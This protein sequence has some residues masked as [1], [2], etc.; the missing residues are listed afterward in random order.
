MRKNYLTVEIE[1]EYFDTQDV[2]LAS[3]PVGG[4]NDGTI[5]DIYGDPL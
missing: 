3:A 1:F 5:D 4:N 2:V